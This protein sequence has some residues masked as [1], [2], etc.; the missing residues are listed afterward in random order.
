MFSRVIPRNA[1]ATPSAPA[2]AAASRT[3]IGKYPAPGAAAAAESAAA[4]FREA[5]RQTLSRGLR[6]GARTADNFGSCAPNNGACGAGGVVDREGAG[7]SSFASGGGALRRNDRDDGQSDHR[8][9][10]RQGQRPRPL[11]RSRSGSGLRQ[12][13]SSFDPLV[14]DEG[15]VLSL[16]LCPPVLSFSAPSS[17]GNA[18]DGCKV[19][20]S[21]CVTGLRLAS[22][23]QPV[24][25]DAAV[26]GDF[27]VG[28]SSEKT[29][30]VPGFPLPVQAEISEEGGRTGAAAAARVTYAVLACQEDVDDAVAGALIGGDVFAPDL[31]GGSVAR[32]ETEGG[33][34]SGTVVLG[35]VE[36][37][38]SWAVIGREL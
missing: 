18:D 3:A 38:V 2:S 10:Q 4:A 15:A 24:T 29:A 12:L 21:S 1:S 34:V 7:L 14:L 27:V 19:N 23:A 16:G 26:T 5:L 22:Q 28:F 8:H 37:Q 30:G 36:R 25:A 17:R 33:I 9:P 31:Q 20:D 11:P 35:G 13:V 6:G 32:E